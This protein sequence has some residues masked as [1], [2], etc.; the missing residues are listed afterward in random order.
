MVVVWKRKRTFLSWATRGVVDRLDH[1]TCL[2]RR[3]T[4]TFGGD[5][6]KIWSEVYCYYRAAFRCL[7]ASS[8]SGGDACNSRSTQ[9]T[10]TQVCAFSLAEPLAVECSAS[11]PLGVVCCLILFKQDVTSWLG[12]KSERICGSALSPQCLIIFL[13]L[14]KIVVDQR[15]PTSPPGVRWVL[16][17]DRGA[18][19]RRRRVRVP[20]V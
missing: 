6:A 18:G 20:K 17:R 3:R 14:G 15:I 13:F 5:W 12:S 10:H 19:L 16:R 1:G 8:I 2:F 11:W 9:Y 4:P 7:T